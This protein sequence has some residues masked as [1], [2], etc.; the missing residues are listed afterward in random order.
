MQFIVLQDSD[1]DDQVILT[2]CLVNFLFTNHKEIQCRHTNPLTTVSCCCCDWGLSCQIR[3]ST[4]IC[5][6]FYKHYAIDIVDPS[7]MQD[8]CHMNFVIDFAHCGV[9]VAQL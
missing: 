1:K 3:L 5:A 7:S 6:Y 2:S 4:N 8:A 9:S